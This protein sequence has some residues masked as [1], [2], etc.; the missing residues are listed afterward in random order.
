MSSLG[1]LIF[2]LVA[3]MAFW[4]LIFLSAILPYWIGLYIIEQFNPKLAAKLAG[5]PGEELKKD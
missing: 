5:Y 4:V 1:F 2:V 3:C